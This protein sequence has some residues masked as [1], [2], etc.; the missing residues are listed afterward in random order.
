MATKVSKVL[1][2]ERNE[3][4]TFDLMGDTGIL[5]P[6]QAMYV[7]ANVPNPASQLIEAEDEVQLQVKVLKNIENMSNFDWVEKNIDP[8]L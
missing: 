6:G 7:Y 1:F 4:H 2:Y 8:Y 3:K 5:T